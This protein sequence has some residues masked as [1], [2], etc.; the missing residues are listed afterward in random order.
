MGLDF[1]MIPRLLNRMGVR[2]IQ[3]IAGRT[4]KTFHWVFFSS[5]TKKTGT[6]MITAITPIGSLKMGCPSIA[7]PASETCGLT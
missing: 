2:K 7:P 1:G 5:Q 3:M 6:M 4:V